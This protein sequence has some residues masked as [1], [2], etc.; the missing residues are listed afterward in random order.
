MASGVAGKGNLL[1]VDVL[2]VR[3]RVCSKSTVNGLEKNCL[4]RSIS[5]PAPLNRKN[6]M[7]MATIRRKTRSRRWNMR[8]SIA[9]K[10]IGGHRCQGCRFSPLRRHVPESDRSK[11]AWPVLVTF[12]N[13]SATRYIGFRA[14]TT[15]L[16]SSRVTTSSLHGTSRPPEMCIEG[17]LPLPVM[18]TVSVSCVARE[19]ASRMA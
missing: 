1:S 5:G 19:S 14:F 8:F 18:S 11:A 12:W 16:S 2:L 6:K 3:S 15:A 17:S 9:E 4:R 13:V 7:P 10:V